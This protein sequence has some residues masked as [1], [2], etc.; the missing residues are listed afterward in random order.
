MKL[1][2]APV[3]CHLRSEALFIQESKR[4]DKGSSKKKSK[5]KKD[6]SISGSDSD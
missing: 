5:S 3:A 1:D 2:L 4:K 6:S